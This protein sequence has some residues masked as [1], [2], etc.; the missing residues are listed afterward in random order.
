MV[1]LLWGKRFIVHYRHQDHPDRGLL[2]LETGLGGHAVDIFSE[3]APLLLDRLHGV[4]ALLGVLVRFEGVLEGGRDAGDHLFHVLF[5]L[6]AL[7]GRQGQAFGFDA[8]WKLYTYTQSGGTGMVFAR[9]LT[10]S[11]AAVRLPFPGTPA[12][13]MLK[14]LLL[15][16]RP[17]WSA[18]TARSCPMIL[19]EGITSLVVR[20]SNGNSGQARRHCSG[21]S[22]LTIIIRPSS[23]RFYAHP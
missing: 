20:Q 7:S 14:P 2:D 9:S 6:F 11:T 19:F 21:E 8:S 1:E 4:L 17:N 18:F 3:I 23:A 22:S 13:Y 15:I 12:M 10:K 5:E 16:L